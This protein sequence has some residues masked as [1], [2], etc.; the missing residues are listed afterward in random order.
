[1]IDLQLSE[2]H[3]MLRDSVN[4]YVELD[5]VPKVSD[6]E[7]KAFGQEIG[8]FQLIQEHFAFMQAGYDQSQLLVHKAGWLKNQGI[9]N[10]RESGMAKW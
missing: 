8:K 3:L 5:V 9:E 6:H 4:D 2:K 1:M 7:R 10:T